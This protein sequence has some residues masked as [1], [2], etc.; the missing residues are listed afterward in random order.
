MKFVVTIV[1]A[2]FMLVCIAGQVQSFRFALTPGKVKCFTN[3]IYE[4]GKYEVRYTMMQSLTPFVSVSV[5]APSGR[6][7]FEHE[8]AHAEGK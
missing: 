3:D 1:A 8:V 5:N 2:V 6:V 4:Q 7:L